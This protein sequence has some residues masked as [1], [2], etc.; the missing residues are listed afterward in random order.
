MSASVTHSRLAGAGLP[1]RGD[2]CPTL[3]PGEG[4]VARR[5]RRGRAAKEFVLPDG[6]A[7]KLGHSRPF[8]RARPRNAPQSRRPAAETRLAERA[9]KDNNNDGARRTPNHPRSSRDAPGDHTTP[10]VPPTRPVRPRPG[11][12]TERSHSRGPPDRGHRSSPARHPFPESDRSRPADNFPSTGQPRP[13]G[14]RRSQN[15]AIC[16]GAERS[17]SRRRRTKPL[18]SARNEAIRVGAERSHSRRRGTKP[19]ASARNEAILSRAERSHSR[20]RGTKPLLSLRNEA[21]FSRRKRAGE[22]VAGPVGVCQ[23]VIRSRPGT[24]SAAIPR[25]GRRRRVGRRGGNSLDGGGC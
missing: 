14:V 19:F 17:H 20:R 18:A 4:P 7:R 11:S 16:G 10:R 15:E 8:F 25:A 23:N 5:K 2:C 6:D 24:P 22:S 12:P 9:R 13:A 1:D 21:T 3:P